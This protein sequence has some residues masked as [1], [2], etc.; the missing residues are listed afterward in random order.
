MK[1]YDSGTG[2]DAVIRF[3]GYYL[4]VVPIA[5]RDKQCYM[6]ER[7][8]KGGHISVDLPALDSVPTGWKCHFI[9]AK[10]TALRINPGEGYEIVYFDSPKRLIGFTK[11]VGQDG[12]VRFWDCEELRLD[13]VAKDG[14]EVV[15][16]E[17]VNE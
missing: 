8:T 5:G 14:E 16:T 7:P 13:D 1:I 3:K 6:L 17:T 10:G 2:Y 11:M 4:H 12:I 9:V 15:E